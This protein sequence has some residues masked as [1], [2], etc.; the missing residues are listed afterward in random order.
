MSAAANT[1]PTAPTKTTAIAATMIALDKLHESPFNKRRTWGNLNELADSIKE[2]GVLEPLLARAH[3]KKAGEHELVFGH[4]RYRA[5]KLA[6]VPSVPVQVRTLTDEETVRIQVVENLQRT[7]LHPLEEAESFEQALKIGHLTAEDLA[8]KLGK[9]RSHVFQRLKLLTLCDKVREAFAK[10]EIA[11]S[12][13]LYIARIP[14]AKLQIEAL[15]DCLGDEWHG[16]LSV[17]RA[18]EHITQQFMLN[19][20]AAPFSRDDATLLP[21]AGTCTAC[22]KRTGNQGELFADVTS[23]NACTDPPCF[24]QKKEAHT[25]RRL[26]LAEDQGQ[27]VLEGKAAEE[28]TRYGSSFIKLD[29]KCY[30]DP[31]NRTYRELTKGAD[32]EVTLAKDKSGEVHELVPRAAATKVLPKKA[33]ADRRSD[34]GNGS[35]FRNEAK[36]RQQAAERKRVRTLAVLAAVVDAA[37]KKLDAATF[38]PFLADLTIRAAG[39]DAL[40]EVTKRRGIEVP[41]PKP[42]SYSNDGNEKALRKALDAMPSVQAR[43][44][45]VELALSHGTFH[46]GEYG[47]GELGRSLTAAAE[48]YRVNVEKV[49]KAAVVAANEKKA[50]RKKPSKKAK[51]K[52]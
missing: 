9:S 28:A 16:P 17:R 29:E 30:D 12:V 6:T 38:W 19:L 43:G 31:K 2:L 25:K 46:F 33:A 5:A 13:A 15:K 49:G 45:A 48:Y 8:A 23:G 7:D 11:A 21:K 34:A 4:R 37:E 47:G 26:K 24:Q 32:L 36:K 14:V 35:S 52:S 41:K 39:A 10:D 27:K 20:D 3:P 40:R 1:I 18:H 50:A 51:G 22:P 44:L 42:G